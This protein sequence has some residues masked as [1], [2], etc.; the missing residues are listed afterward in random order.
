MRNRDH[1]ALCMDI[2]NATRL[3]LAD[4][5]IELDQL[6]AALVLQAAH[7]ESVPLR[8]EEMLEAA[9]ADDS[10]YF[11]SVVHDIGGLMRHFNP[12][13]RELEDCF[14]PRFAQMEASSN[15]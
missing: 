15:D 14:L 12:L 4:M 9:R 11:P 3:R 7:T 2:A 8:L 1:F 10:P 5:D 6:G 13:T